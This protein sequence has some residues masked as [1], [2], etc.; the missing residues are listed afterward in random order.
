[1]NRLIIKVHEG[2][3]DALATKLVGKVIEMGK[4]SNNNRQYCYLTRFP[5]EGR[6]VVVTCDMVKTG[7][8]FNV[9]V[10]GSLG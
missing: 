10:E 7:Y 3:S 2:V 4:I 5:E 8:S 6:Y 9:Y 1:M